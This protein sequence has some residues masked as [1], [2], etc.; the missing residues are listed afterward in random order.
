M[1]QDALGMCVWHCRRACTLHDT[2]FGA[3]VVQSQVS[4]V[5]PHSHGARACD[6]GMLQ[7]TGKG[8]GKYADKENQAYGQNQS[9]GSRDTSW[10]TNKRQREWG[11][12]DKG[13]KKKK[14][15]K[16]CNLQA[17][18][19]VAPQCAFVVAGQMLQLSRVRALCQRLP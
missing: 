3:P 12:W 7:E 14:T 17:H 16:V 18:F 19:S 13:N 15:E 8:K 5:Y 10:D 2:L 1:Q 4:S 6:I 11:S 9:G